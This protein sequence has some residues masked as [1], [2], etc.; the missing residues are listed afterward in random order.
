MRRAAIVLS[1]CGVLTAGVVTAPPA[2]A[3]PAD[4]VDQLVTDLSSAPIPDPKN[5][6]VIE[7]LN[8]H[9]NDAEIEA[10]AAHVTTAAT[11]FAACMVPDPA[12]VLACVNG[13]VDDIVQSVIWQSSDELY[14]RYVHLHEGGVS[15]YGENAVAD[16]FAIAGCL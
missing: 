7:G 3:G 11:N 4:C 15:V 6:V 9:V 5:V 8:I 13:V 16:A 14:L 1:L 10:F 12:Q 2:S